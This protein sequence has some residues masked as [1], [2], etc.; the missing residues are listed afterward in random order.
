MR[1]LPSSLAAAQFQIIQ[2]DTQEKP[3]EVFPNEVIM[4]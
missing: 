3:G 2:F 1:I 4:C